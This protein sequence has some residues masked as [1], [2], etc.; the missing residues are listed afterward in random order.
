[1]WFKG[2]CPLCFVRAILSQQRSS[3]SLLDLV[4]NTKIMLVATQFMLVATQVANCI[5]SYHH[6]WYDYKDYDDD[7]LAVLGV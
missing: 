2:C 3:L 1:M 7:G 4:L 5:R 6:H